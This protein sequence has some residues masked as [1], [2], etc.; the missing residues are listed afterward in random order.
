MVISRKQS[1]QYKLRNKDCRKETKTRIESS[2]R[3]YRKRNQRRSEGV[4][5]EDLK[6]DSTCAKLAHQQLHI[7]ALKLF[8]N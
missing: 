7:S 4:F 5:V 3:L 1:V 6:Q 2:I 8:L